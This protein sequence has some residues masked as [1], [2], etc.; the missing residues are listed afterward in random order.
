MKMI[1]PFIHSV[2]HALQG[3]VYVFHSQK[4][5]RIQLVFTA[6]AVLGILFFPLQDSEILAVLLVAGLVLVLELINTSVEKLIDMIEPRMHTRAQVSKDAL[7][8]AVLVAS[9]IA[10]IV[11]MYIFIPHLRTLFA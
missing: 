10:V 8:A 5:F 9:L 4:N 11:G 7:A 6:V 3:L 2:R 1:Q